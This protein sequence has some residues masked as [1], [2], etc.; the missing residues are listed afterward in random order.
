MCVDAKKDIKY[1]LRQIQLNEKLK[2]WDL[3]YCSE[4]EIVS[5]KDFNLNNCKIWVIVKSE[6]SCSV[7]PSS[8]QSDCEDLKEY[9]L[10]QRK[11]TEKIKKRNEI[12]NMLD[13]WEQDIHFDK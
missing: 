2:K 10:E 9:F 3:S 1:N 4:K 5:K 8:L 6:K 7:L 13:W 12:L 11:K